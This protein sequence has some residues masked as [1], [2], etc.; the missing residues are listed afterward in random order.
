MSKKLLS[1]IL[2]LIGA[3]LLWD[4]TRYRHTE[5]WWFKRFL[6]YPGVR[7]DTKGLLVHNSVEMAYRHLLRLKEHHPEKIRPELPL[8]KQ[9]SVPVNSDWFQSV[10][11]SFWWVDMTKP[12][13]KKKMNAFQKGFITRMEALAELDRK[14]AAIRK[15]YE[16][17]NV[18]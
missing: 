18:K 6:S 17:G 7:P 1:Y 12:Y 15:K 4:Y 16:D 5:M 13:D 2:V 3:W 8:E 11:R 14:A 10:P 9:L